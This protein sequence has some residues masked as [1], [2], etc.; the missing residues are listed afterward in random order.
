MEKNY[1]LIIFDMDGT[2]VDSSGDITQTVN[3][4]ANK[5][6]FPQ[7]SNE[8]VK[9]KIIGGARNILLECFGHENKNLIDHEILE[10]FNQNYT[11]NCHVFSELYPGIFE[12]I[13]YYYEKHKVLAIATY[14]TRTATEKILKIFKIDRYFDIVVTA[15]D[16]EKPK[17]NP[18]CIRKILKASAIDKERAILI[19]DAEL[20]CITARNAGID[21]CTVTYGFE[22]KEKLEGIDS[23]YKVEKAEKI[24]DFVL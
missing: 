1:D 10:R 14:K 3:Y 24:K 22:E 12:L 20:D 4:L 19:G 6:G 15:D 23:T 9:S 8:F 13:K 16:V 5:Y 17:P 18:E 7:R 2:L 11:N 21:I